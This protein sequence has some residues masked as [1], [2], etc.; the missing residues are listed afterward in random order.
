MDLRVPPLR[1]EIV[2][3]SNPVTSIIL[4][5]RL[6]VDHKCMPVGGMLLVILEQTVPAESS[7]RVA[8]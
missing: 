2:L 7:G 4:V 3:E 5:R 6:A 8:V 1:I